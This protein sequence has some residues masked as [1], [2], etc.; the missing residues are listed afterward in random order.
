LEAEIRRAT[1]A[2]ADELHVDVM[3]GHFVP[4]ISFGPSVVQMAARC[5]DI[6]LSVHLMLSR[7]DQYITRFVEAGASCIHIHIEAECNVEESLRRIRDLGRSPG[8][9]LNPET[10]ASASWPVLDMVDQVLCMTVRPGYGG[11]S[12]MADV[13]PKIRLV[14]EHADG[15]GLRHLSVMVDGGI[16]SR[17]GAQ[18]AR[19]GADAFVAGSFLFRASDMAAEIQTMRRSID[20]ARAA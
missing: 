13:L 1:A 14:R 3:D 10:P 20:E 16:D 19:E 4:N 9:T 11:Q 17:T 2:G 5:T 8:I 12:F 7:P 18:C 15:R 6:P